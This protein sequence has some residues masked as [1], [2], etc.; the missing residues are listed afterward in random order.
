MLRALV[1]VALNCLAVEALI[2]K[3][4]VRV[5]GKD[6]ERQNVAHAEKEQTSLK[7]AAT[8]QS[9]TTEPE[10]VT[11]AVTTMV[12]L[13]DAI[14]QVLC[15][16]RHTHELDA[17]SEAASNVYTEKSNASVSIVD[18]PVSLL[19]T[20]VETEIGKMLT[21][22]E[23]TN[24]LA[25]LSKE[26]ELISSAAAKR[27]ILHQVNAAETMMLQKDIN[28][29]VFNILARSG[30]WMKLSEKMHANI[31][32]QWQYDKLRMQRADG[33]NINSKE[34][35]VFDPPE[36]EI[37]NSENTNIEQTNEPEE[38][39]SDNTD[40]DTEEKENENMDDGASVTTP[41]INS[42]L[43]NPNSRWYK[44]W[45]KRETTCAEVLSNFDN[46][47]VGKG[48]DELA[49]QCYEM[50]RRSVVDVQN[51]PTP[52]IK[53]LQ[54]NGKNMV[55][56]KFNLGG[57]CM[58]GINTVLTKDRKP[59]CS[60]VCGKNDQ[61]NDLCSLCQ[62]ML[63][64][65]V[66]VEMID[67]VN[68][69]TD[70]LATFSKD[71]CRLQFPTK[72]DRWQ[73]SETFTKQINKKKV[74]TYAATVLKDGG[75]RTDVKWWRANIGSAPL[76]QRKNSVETGFSAKVQV[77]FKN[78]WS[79]GFTPVDWK[80][81]RFFVHD[82]LP[83]ELYR[84]NIENGDAHGA[85][86]GVKLWKLNA[87][88]R[89]RNLVPMIARFEF[90]NVG[91]PVNE[92]LSMKWLFRRE[93]FPFAGY[94]ALLQLIFKKAATTAKANV[95]LGSDVWPF[96]LTT[97]AIKTGRD[98]RMR[99]GIVYNVKFQ[100]STP[101]TTPKYNSKLVLRCSASKFEK[102]DS[103]TNRKNF[104]EI[105]AGFAFEPFVL[106]DLTFSIRTVDTSKPNQGFGN[107]D[108]FG[109]GKV[110]PKEPMNVEAWNFL[111]DLL[112]ENDGNPDTDATVVTKE[113][114]VN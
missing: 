44:W 29:T 5:M 17:F 108:Q 60:D 22:A 97:T 12:L 62:A 9:F 95:I 87:I 57:I 109:K 71:D 3:S 23:K 59:E 100:V 8:L 24:V 47:Y 110:T 37:K 53:G 101:S 103:K 31:G 27:Q 7:L 76:I 36:P 52:I 112:F 80:G 89:N 88:W 11:V 68:G 20:A 41:T 51:I 56:D 32:K 114:M 1:R 96:D 85:H 33:G 75:R 81:L 111:R 70:C 49:S 113:E 14:E 34:N 19:S 42:K 107:T 18:V 102:D 2:R 91:H 69:Y 15:R 105:F 77:V 21:S 94:M 90:F 58:A 61:N 74:Q 30:K 50:L 98:L 65:K 67:Y 28:E 72:K 4:N 26:K 54:V 46:D 6:M 40:D 55:E 106:A 64:I 10:Q 39:E 104:V 79:I 78:G 45:E 43:A 25:A 73:V 93:Y 16:E 13:Q 99:A 63:K 92:K 35:N 83:T 66:C 48:L 82:N 38:K 86:D 84:L